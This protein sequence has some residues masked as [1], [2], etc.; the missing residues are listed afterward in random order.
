MSSHMSVARTT[1]SAPKSATLRAAKMLPICCVC[2]RIRDETKSTLRRERWV[3]PRTYRQ[4]HGVDSTKLALTH[5]YCLKCF[6]KVQE[7]VRQ[8]LR[9]IGTPS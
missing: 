2:G 5:T 8:L 9:T 1:P 6:A 7:E 3:S 4:T